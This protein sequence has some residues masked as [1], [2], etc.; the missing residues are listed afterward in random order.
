[1]KLILLSARN[2]THTVRWANA[3]VERGHEVHVVSIQTGGPALDARVKVH[4]L[5]HA[6]PAGYLTNVFRLRKLIRE[7]KPDVMNVHYASGYGVLGMLSRFH[8]VC[9]NVWGSDVYEFPFLNPVNKRL[10]RQVLRSADQV[11]STS[12]AMAGQTRS[13][14]TT[15]RPIEVTPFGVDTARFAPK[16]KDERSIV[17]GTIKIL[18]PIYGQTVLI[19]A[20]AAALR[21]TETKRPDVAAKMRLL[22]VGDGPMRRELE[23]R[24]KDRGI[25]A[26]T[27]FT[28][29]VEHAE[30]PG[31]LAKLDV[32]VAV[33]LVDESFG[34]AV[35]EA[36]SAG[37]PVVVSDV[38]GFREVVEDGRTGLIV[39]RNDVGATCEAIQKLVL[40]P[41]LR[42]KMGQAGRERV[43][44]L[45]EW[46][47]CVDKL[48]GV[49]RNL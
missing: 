28:G 14:A 36:S 26:R 13:L 18:A 40:N 49:L 45:Y 23:E 41:D 38:P 12:E 2:S 30:I 42:G 27:T 6:A 7:I 9:V 44:R 33:T 17:V 35:V 25:A 47:S 48:E 43:Q 24:C 31:F 4:F 32:F 1:M 8:P 46:K 21:H 3:F 20:F 37:V 10:I 16:P 39:P 22:L 34:V 5:P 29:A 19:D 15:K 11:A